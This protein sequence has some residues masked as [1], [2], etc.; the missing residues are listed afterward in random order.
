MDVGLAWKLLEE[1]RLD[2]G[3]EQAK[4]EDSKPFHLGSV[5]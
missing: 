5:L 4:V 3:F 2:E 1:R